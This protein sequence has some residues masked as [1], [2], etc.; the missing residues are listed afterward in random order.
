MKDGTTDQLQ[1][2]VL[3]SLG[4]DFLFNMIARNSAGQMEL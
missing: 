3:I 1:I 2:I 4:L